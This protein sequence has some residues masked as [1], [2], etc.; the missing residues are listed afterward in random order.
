V[1]YMVEGHALAEERPKG[2]TTAMTSVP[3]RQ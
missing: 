3:F 1:Y 2:D